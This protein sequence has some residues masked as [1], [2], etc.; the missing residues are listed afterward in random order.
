MASV[1]PVKVR[2]VTTAQMSIVFNTTNSGV[3]C[4][5]RRFY[6]RYY[7]R[8]HTPALICG[9]TGMPAPRIQMRTNLHLPLQFS[10]TLHQPRHHPDLSR[11]SS[12]GFLKVPLPKWNLC[13]NSEGYGDSY[14][15]VFR[16]SVS[17]VS[18][19]FS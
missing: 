3:A 5:S 16:S 6:P 11:L 8:P 15:N 19:W 18:Q 14:T 12:P 1:T 13:Y 17:S 10:A 2:T 9:V 7:A 4:F